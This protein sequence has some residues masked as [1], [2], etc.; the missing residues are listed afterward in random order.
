MKPYPPASEANGKVDTAEVIHR[1]LGRELL[2]AFGKGEVKLHP[3]RPEQRC[4]SGEIADQDLLLHRRAV[5]EAI[6]VEEDIM[7]DR[8][9][10]EAPI[11]VPAE[12]LRQACGIEPGCAR[13]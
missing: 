8:A 7:R 10:D 13:L 1:L 2:R 3:I 12:G 11:E 5:L 6:A 9:A 4:T